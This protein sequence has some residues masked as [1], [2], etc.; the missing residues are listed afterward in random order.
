MVADPAWRPKPGALVRSAPGFYF[1]A[2]I[3]RVTAGCA[4]F[5]TLIQWFCRPPRSARSRRLET[6]P[7]RP[8][9][10]AAPNRSV[11]ISPASNGVTNMPSGRPR[12]SR[13]KLDAQ[14][15]WQRPQILAAEGQDIE[16]VELDLVVVPARVQGVKVGNAVNPEHDGLA[17]DDELLLAVL[18]RSQPQ[19]GTPASGSCCRYDRGRQSS[20]QAQRF[21]CLFVLGR[22]RSCAEATMP[23]DKFSHFTQMTSSAQ[24]FYKE[25][26][27][28]RAEAVRSSNQIDREGWLKLAGEW[29]ELALA[30]ERGQI[31]RR[32]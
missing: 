1:C 28:C 19:I 22:E 23:P 16:G 17:V 4:R 11:P 14:A 18:Q 10:Q 15:Q 3:T 6:S 12:S 26:A 13:A 8:M 9:R 20:E 32:G 30:A 27:A 7:S 5:L 29:T 21:A 31:F 25:A 2:S 24:Q